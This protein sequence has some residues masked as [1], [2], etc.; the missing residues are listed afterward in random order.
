MKM[1][2]NTEQLSEEEM[3]E[4]DFVVIG[5]AYFAPHQLKKLSEVSV[6]H[7]CTDYKIKTKRGLNTTQL[8]AELG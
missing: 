8:L 6:K 3:T 2:K 4:N 5:K 7:V 1:P